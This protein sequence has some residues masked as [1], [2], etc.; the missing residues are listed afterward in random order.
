MRSY[1]F[2]LLV[3]FVGK[4]S[5]QEYYE[6]DPV[7]IDERYD[8]FMP[9]LLGGQIV[10]SSTNADDVVIKYTD[11]GTKKSPSS[12]YIATVKDGKLVGNALPLARNIRTSLHQ[13][14]ATFSEDG[15]TM[16]FTRN[17][18]VDQWI[19]NDHKDHNKLGL[20]TTEMI[21]GEWSAPVPFKYNNESYNV[22]HPT[23]ST[24]GKRL[25]FVSDMPGTYGGT[26]LYVCEMKNGEWDRPKN[27]GKKV[28]S[29]SNEMFPTVVDNNMI[30]FSSDRKGGLGGLDIYVCSNIGSAWS[31]PS[32]LETPLN[33][34][35]DD[36]G[37]APDKKGR[38]GYISSN[39]NGK[40]EIFYFKRTIP[41][42]KDCEPQVEN[43]FCYVFEEE[44]TLES[45]SLPLVYQWDLGD[46]TT[47]IGNEAE[48]CY[49]GPGEYIVKLNIIDTLTK[50]IFFNEASYT[51][52]I[53]DIEQPYIS[54]EGPMY[55]RHLLTFSAENSRLEKKN[56]AEYHWDLADST[57]RIG[58]EVNKRFHESGNKVIKLDVIF[59]PDS[60]GKITHQCVTRTLE[61]LQPK[62][63]VDVSDET[64][65]VEYTDA[66]GQI[67]QFIYQELPYDLFD[68]S[69]Q[70]GEDIFFT[71][72]LLASKERVSTSDPFFDK[73]REKYRILENYISQ[74]EH[75]S[76]S[77]GS[78]GIL[79]DVFP[80]F[81]DL[82]AMEYERAV[83]KAIKVE[84]VKEIGNPED[85]AALKNLNVEDLNN[86]VL[87]MS[88]VYFKTGDH[89]IDSSFMGTLDKLLEIV[90]AFDKINLEISAH[91]D[92]MGPNS[93]NKL[94]SER[95]AE[96][97][98]E[99]LVGKGLRIDRMK[100]IGYGEDHPI[101]SNIEE[102]GRKLNRRVEFKLVTNSFL[103]SEQ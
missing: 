95:R 14:P 52:K 82:K 8:H 92:D 41:L 62:Q 42:F 71:V 37:F 3:L 68:I 21:D 75:F 91:T 66:Q 80:I 96:S 53:E 11:K 89:T 65:V 26:D 55:S 12:I 90:I 39:R 17:L 98:V 73:A 47:I 86:T 33:S 67:H 36:M 30:Y 100:A 81:S 35:A 45:D 88:T 10:F 99:Y 58:L 79:E 69:V 38:T 77:I 1:W 97:I 103:S 74:D 59:E 9:V 2:I 72:Q 70:D 22:G 51:L 6:I 87:R 56:I 78:E 4:I 5:A 76:Y 57:D 28:N 60:T 31:T 54:F 29:H 48:H 13:G 50:S 44:G 84:K 102:E 27:L 93:F 16:I 83:V 18:H 7:E 63:L 43:G 23:L 32:G 101:A 40:D 34:P 20:F 24:D 94:L 49:E 61:L 19:G 85:M 15:I 64:V 25:F 46:G